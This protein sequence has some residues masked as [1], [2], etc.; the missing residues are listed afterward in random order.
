M[1]P[2][3][4]RAMVRRNASLAASPGCGCGA[5]RRAAKRLQPWPRPHL[6]RSWLKRRRRHVSRRFVLDIGGTLVIDDDL[7]PVVAHVPGANCDVQ[8]SSHGRCDAEERYCQEYR[9]N[10][11]SSCSMHRVPPI[12]TSFKH[13]RPQSTRDSPAGAVQIADPCSIRHG[14]VAKRNQDHKHY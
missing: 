11:E 4:R 1:V 12:Q 6:P 2:P 10:R 3:S 7:E 9:Y 5:A 8:R 14:R 13:P